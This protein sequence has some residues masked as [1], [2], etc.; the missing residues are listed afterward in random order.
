[1]EFA[2][3]HSVQ[4]SCRKRRRLASAAAVVAVVAAAAAAEAATAG[5]TVVTWAPTQKSST[6]FSVRSNVL[7]TQASHRKLRCHLSCLKGTD[8]DDSDW[9]IRRRFDELRVGQELTG[10]VFRIT[11]FGCFVDVRA[12]RCGLV[13]KKDVSLSFDTRIDQ[14]LKVGDEVKVWVTKVHDGQLSLTMVNPGAPRRRP[15]RR[16]IK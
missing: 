4:R 15:V 1:M 10:V 13:K 11:D 9:F 3:I 16:N 8:A 2:S 5:L 6:S 12:E 7:S 14:I